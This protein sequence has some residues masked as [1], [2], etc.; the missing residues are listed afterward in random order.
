MIDLT[1]AVHI[2]NFTQSKY[3]DCYT[4]NLPPTKNFG[5]D[6]GHDVLYRKERCVGIAPTE[7][8][9]NEIRFYFQV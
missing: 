2:I 6:V 7:P 1:D 9:E 8:E 4:A 5:F 3:G